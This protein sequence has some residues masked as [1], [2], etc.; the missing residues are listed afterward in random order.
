MPEAHP[1]L[2]TSAMKL[3]DQGVVELVTAAQGG[4][5]VPG[6]FFGDVGLA[7]YHDLADRVPDEVKTQIEELTPQVIS[8][9]VPTGVG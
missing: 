9:E 7:D 5:L 4:T 3:I 2:V 8:G 1:C 6:N